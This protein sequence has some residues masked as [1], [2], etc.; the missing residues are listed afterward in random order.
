MVLQCWFL[1]DTGER[2][3]GAC[4]V[5]VERL[6]IKAQGIDSSSLCPPTDS[7]CPD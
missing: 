1:D 4:L 2:L 3:T 6:T 5:E 7:A